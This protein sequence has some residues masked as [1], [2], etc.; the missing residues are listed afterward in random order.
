MARYDQ[1]QDGSNRI[2]EAI[3]PQLEEEALFSVDNP[4]YKKSDP[5]ALGLRRKHLTGILQGYRKDNQLT[6]GEKQALQYVRHELRKTRLKQRPS[7]A[8]VLLYAKPLRWLINTL[9]GRQRYYNAVNRE[10]DR[11]EKAI[12]IGPNAANLQQALKDYGFVNQ[13]EHALRVR[14]AYGPDEFSIRTP[15]VS[16]SDTNYLLHFKKIEGSHTYYFAGFDVS[17]RSTGIY[18]PTD[19]KQEPVLS[20]RTTDKIQLTA[21]D[22]QRLVHGAPISK[23]VDGQPIW[24]ALSADGRRLETFSFS[25]EDKLK[26]LPIKEM[27]LAESRQALLSDL[28]A[29]KEAFMTLQL[30]SGEEKGMIGSVVKST[31]DQKISMSFRDDIGKIDPFDLTKDRSKAQQILQNINSPVLTKSRTL[32]AV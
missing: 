21:E 18:R 5:K 3:K 19:Q 4:S 29:G 15:E 30:P 2:I 13:L 20:V 8:R 32:R 7:L 25:L 17:K 10:M 26:N 27:N 24:I 23:I 1:M 31:Q 22:A 12:V 11:V 9:R 6:Y 28:T 14:L 16:K